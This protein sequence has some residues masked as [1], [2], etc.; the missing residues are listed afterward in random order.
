MD[1]NHNDGLNDFSGIEES[2]GLS[3]INS[4]DDLPHIKKMWVNW[5]IEIN[6][7]RKFWRIILDI[8]IRL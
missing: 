3:G 5:M 4:L 1:T 8:L 6:F 7:I 2:E